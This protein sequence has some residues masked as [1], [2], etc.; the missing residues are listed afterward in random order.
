MCLRFVGRP[1]GALRYHFRVKTLLADI[2]NAMLQHCMARIG[3]RQ[4]LTL[5]TSKAQALHLL[6][7]GPGFD[8]VVAGDRLEDGSGLALLDEVHAYWPHLTRVFC[9][10]RHRL[11]LVRQRLLM[12]RLRHTLPYP[13]KPVKLELLLLHLDHAKRALAN[14]GRAPPR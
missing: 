5:A 13:I 3:A 7:H 8:V 4:H 11:A 12:F 2:D 9:I 14:G 10:D 1:D 6:H